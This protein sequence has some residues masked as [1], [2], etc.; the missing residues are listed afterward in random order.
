ML[1]TSLKWLLDRVPTLMV[2]PQMRASMKLV[3]AL[4]PYLAYVGVFV[5]WSWGAIKS[6]DKGSLLLYAL[7]VATDVTP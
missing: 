1:T 4:V 3:K 5:A 7:A 6:F 2:P